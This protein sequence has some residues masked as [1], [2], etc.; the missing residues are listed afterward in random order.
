[1]NLIIAQ[2]HNG[3]RSFF[4]NN[5]GGI[6]KHDTIGLALWPDAKLVF[7]E[8][9]IP[10][11][12][13]S[14]IFNNKDHDTLAEEVTRV[15]E[16][17]WNILFPGVKE[18]E[19]NGINASVLYKYEIEVSLSSLLL[20]ICTVIKA[21]KK[22]QPDK[23]I[24]IQ[25]NFSAIRNRDDLLNKHLGFVNYIGNY[26]WQELFIDQIRNE[27]GKEAIIASVASSDRNG[28]KNKYLMFRLSVL[29]WQSV[30]RGKGYLFSVLKRKLALSDGNNIFKRGEEFAVLESERCIGELISILEKSYKIAYIPEE[31]LCNSFS[32]SKCSKGRDDFPDN[33]YRNNLANDSFWHNNKDKF[34]IEG[35]SYS[36]V[37]KDMAIFI[38]DQYKYL[39]EHYQF[40]RKNLAVNKPR[41]YFTVSAGSALGR[42]NIWAFHNCGTRTVWHLDGLAQPNN[43]IWKVVKSAFWPESPAEKWLVSENAYRFFSDNGLDSDKLRVTG[44]LERGFQG[45]PKI[46]SKA[47][48][49]F[50][51]TMLNIP[52]RSKIILYAASICH[53]SAMRLISEQ[54]YFEILRDIKDITEVF[55]EQEDI[56]T[57]I[58]LHPMSKDLNL[59]KRITSHIK[60]RNI[61]VNIPIQ[62][63][64]DISDVVIVYHS[65]VGLEALYRGKHL[66]VYNTTG[67][68][69][70]LTEIVTDL[71]HDPAN[72]PTAKIV[73]NKE[74]LFSTVKQ[75]FTAKFAPDKQKNESSPGLSYYLANADYTFNAVD[76]AYQLLCNE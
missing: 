67:R 49:W 9:S 26:P 8:L 61:L 46:L 5:D 12:T 66:I 76:K 2:N 47:K 74:D 31:I 24:F 51:K 20:K 23:C 21:I 58:K 33:Y 11:I 45:K 41:A 70:Y 53:E 73:R 10:S 42:L 62:L 22:F 7:D 69:S 63:L 71:N 4:K 14:D 48:T 38:L 36:P 44:Y 39:E 54:T 43:K 15:S 1:M 75:L 65:S 16:E 13:A 25:D 18:P 27:L 64:I 32:G 50:L 6:F 56:F 57:I 30:S 68:P 28:K 55:A 37:L 40:L 17:W 34:S 59:I 3:L 19:I 72:G 60:N 29:F 35:V 52:S